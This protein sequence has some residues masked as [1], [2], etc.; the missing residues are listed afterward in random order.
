MILSFSGRIGSGKDTAAQIVQELYPE[1]NWQI[2]GFADKLRQVASLFL[3]IPPEELKKQ[4]VKE[5]VLSREWADPDGTLI[6]VRIFLQRLGTQAVRDGLCKSAWVNALMIDYR[7][8]IIEPEM[9]LGDDFPYF[10]EEVTP[11]WVVTDCR[12]PQEVEAIKNSGGTC[13]RI[14]RP[15]NPYPQS[16]HE[17]ETAIDHIEMLTI[18]N[19]GNLEQLKLRIKE[20]VEPIINPAQSH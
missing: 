9:D 10:F 5:W 14:V 20:T 17:S 11:N 15:D 19:D 16:S 13:I 3:G 18:I 7:S 12:F 1:M 2:K 8:V 6:T 4:E